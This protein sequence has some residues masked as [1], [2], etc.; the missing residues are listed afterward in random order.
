MRR[1]FGGPPNVY[2]PEGTADMAGWR[3]AIRK[4][5]TKDGAE[6]DSVCLC[7]KQDGSDGD[8]GMD[9]LDAGIGV[10]KKAK[11]L[12][13]VVG[14]NDRPSDGYDIQTYGIRFDQIKKLILR[15]R[16]TPTWQQH[17]RAPDGTF[18][19]YE[20]YYQTR[21]YTETSASYAPKGQESRT[22]LLEARYVFDWLRENTNADCAEDAQENPLAGYPEGV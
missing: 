18:P 6:P 10:Y 3:E 13:F 19:E 20:F 8:E 17:T 16:R 5:L 11:L 12:R 9:Y 14:L 1:N 4:Y 15:T 21:I 7:Y 2:V 22:R